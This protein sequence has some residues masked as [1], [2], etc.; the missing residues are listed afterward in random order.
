MIAVIYNPAAGRG[1]V[2]LAQ[3]QAK[4]EA[5]GATDFEIAET[6]PAH[7]A[8]ELAAIAIGNGAKTVMAAG[9]DGTLGEVLG[10]VYGTGAQLGVLPLGTGNDFART[11]GIGADLDRAIA[12]L[13][14]GHRRTIDIGRALYG[15][16]SRLFLNIAGCGFDSLVARRINARRDH[17]LWR[18]MGGRGCLSGGFVHGT[19]T[20]AC[21]AFAPAI[22]WR[23]HR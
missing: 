20:V 8:R 6:S 11:L 19:A 13:I 9:G 21:R 15:E 17:P 4:L 14:R 5:A 16:Q 18:H 7:S 2:S 10:A 1:R 3:L 12:T 23:I 22:G